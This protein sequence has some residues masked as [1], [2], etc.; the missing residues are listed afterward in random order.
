MIL[1]TVVMWKYTTKHLRIKKFM[2]TPDYMKYVK[3][4]TNE[5]ERK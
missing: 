4:C 3:T 2:S 1:L 5:V